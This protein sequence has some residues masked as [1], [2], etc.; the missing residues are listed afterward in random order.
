MMAVLLCGSAFFSGAETAFFNLSRRQI[1]HLAQSSHKLHRLAARISEQRGALLNCL[2]FGNMAVNVLYF[3]AASILALRIKQQ[4]SLMA[5]TVTAFVSFCVLVLAG[6]VLPKSAAYANSRSLS[7]AA[8]VPLAL[9]LRL[10][11]PVESVLRI[12]LVTPVLRLVLGPVRRPDTVT[13]SEFQSL[14]DQIRQR[15]LITADE[16]KLLSGIVELGFLKV[17]DVMQPRVDMRAC[18]VT[19][20]IDTVRALMLQNGLTKA[21]VYVRTKDNIVGLVHLRQLLLRPTT[22]V[23]KLVQHVYFVPEQKTVESLLEFFR[24]R[25]VDTAVVVDE[26]GGIAG[27][28]RLEDIVEELVGP[29]AA[30]ERGRFVEQVGPMQYRLVGDLAIHDWAGAFGIDLAETH[31]STVG[32]FVTAL[33]GRIP[34]VGDVARHKNLKFRVERMRRHRIETVI[35]TFEIVSSDD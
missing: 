6:E 30:G 18:A 7:L 35:L 13:L 17:R 29:V 34:K 5:A 23:D 19:D 10:F 20:S 11:A 9:L 12:L 14:I 22:S 15:G 3:A 2:L 1:E 33:L 21:P 24:T 16:N 32:G 27:S 28:V 8:A 26:Y 31:F 4:V 25:L